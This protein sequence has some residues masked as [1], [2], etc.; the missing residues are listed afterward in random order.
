MTR[1]KNG[2]TKLRARKNTLKMVKGFRHGR[3][4]K[5]RQAYEAIFHAGTYAFAH[6]KD[7]KGDARRNWNVKI[8]YA[9]KS[10]GTSYSKL[11]GGLKKKGVLLDRKILATLSKDSPKTFE[12]IVTMSK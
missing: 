4:T 12:K 1:V 10:L 3:S 11:M 7:K 2:Q 9:S 8:S 5:K 6:R